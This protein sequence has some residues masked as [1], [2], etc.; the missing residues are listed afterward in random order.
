MQRYLVLDATHSQPGLSQWA[1]DQRSLGA[2]STDSGFNFT[3]TLDGPLDP[4]NS[5]RD[6]ME[7]CGQA[8]LG[9]WTSTNC[10]ILRRA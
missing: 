5:L 6:F 2:A 10:A 3:T 9:V 8:G 4:R 1:D 7:V